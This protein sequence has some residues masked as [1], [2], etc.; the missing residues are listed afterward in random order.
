MREDTGGSDPVSV[1]FSFDFWYRIRFFI[2][3]NPASV[4]LIMISNLV[5]VRF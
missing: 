4:P 5:S 2:D 1:R 3:S